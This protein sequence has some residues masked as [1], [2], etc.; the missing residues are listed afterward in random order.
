MLRASIGMTLYCF[1][2]ILE[3]KNPLEEGQ[4]H[5]S[6]CISALFKSKTMKAKVTANTT[7]VKKVL[8]KAVNK[9]NGK[10]INFSR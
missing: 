8:L 9:D 5:E 6:T 10:N 7:A 2:I 1:T 3:G 4:A